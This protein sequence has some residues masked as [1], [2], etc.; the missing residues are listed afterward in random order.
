[1]AEQLRAEKGEGRG[2]LRG[3]FL[4]SFARTKDQNSK[5]SQYEQAASAGREAMVGKDDGGGLPQETPTRNLLQ[6]VRRRSI[7]QPPPLPADP[8]RKGGQSSHGRNSQSGPATLTWEAA[9]KLEDEFEAQ[10]M[11]LKGLQRDNEIKTI[12]VENLRRQMKTVSEFMSK[13]YGAD[14]GAVVFGTDATAAGAF[15]AGIAQN[16]ACSSPSHIARVLTN[17][18]G[19][20]VPSSP[21]KRALVFPD[22]NSLL[23]NE[24]SFVSARADRKS[25]SSE[26]DGFVDELLSGGTGIPPS[27]AMRGSE[28]DTPR[29]LKTPLDSDGSTEAP[30]KSPDARRAGG[31]GRQNFAETTADFGSVQALSTGLKNVRLGS[32]SP[33]KSNSNQRRDVTERFANAADAPESMLSHEQARTILA[34]LDATRL[35]LQGFARRNAQRDEELREMEERAKVQAH[36]GRELLSPGASAAVQD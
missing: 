26:D 8:G 6:K 2:C 27:L 22:D 31:Q 36:Q 15:K 5:G 3:R 19:A 16:P 10:E 20:N 32:T 7:L 1:M 24:D 25:H 28:E 17:N 13:Q 4:T 18:R 23:R 34:Q 14:W 33:T 35:L 11:I 9:K 29:Q 30:E 21:L 12:E